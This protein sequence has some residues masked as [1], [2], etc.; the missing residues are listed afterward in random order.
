MLVFKVMNWTVPE[1]ALMSPLVLMAA[2]DTLYS[3]FGSKSV[4]VTL[5]SEVFTVV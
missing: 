1:N 4:R 2:T 5:V 3:E